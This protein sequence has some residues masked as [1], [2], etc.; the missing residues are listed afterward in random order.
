MRV[1]CQDCGYEWES[2]ARKPK[3]PNPECRS[4][5]VTPVDGENLSVEHVDS[6]NTYEDVQVENYMPEITQ[7]INPDEVMV[8]LSPEAMKKLDLLSEA[9]NMKHSEILERLINIAHNRISPIVV[10]PSKV[11]KVGEFYEIDVDDFEDLK[12]NKLS[13]KF[14]SFTQAVVVAN[15]FNRQGTA[16]VISREGELWVVYYEVPEPSDSA[17][18]LRVTDL[19]GRKL[20][21][22]M[23]N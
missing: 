10:P 9:L 7:V 14:Q 15:S 23:H 12:F 22:R 16:S 13:M 5:N 4:R 8:P 20:S 1:K 17:D 18:V 11:E 3:C 19:F 2:K 21:V 6:S